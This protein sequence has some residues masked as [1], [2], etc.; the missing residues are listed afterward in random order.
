MMCEMLHF[1]LY[2]PYTSAA[3]R[4]LWESLMPTVDDLLT[5]PAARRPTLA[6]GAAAALAANGWRVTHAA[7]YSGRTWSRARMTARVRLVIRCDSRDERLVFSSLEVSSDRLPFYS[8]G[9]DDPV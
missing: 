6:G 7:R 9:D 2:E 5:H 3:I 4:N 8:L 1:L